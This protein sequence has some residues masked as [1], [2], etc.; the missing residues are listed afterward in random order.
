MRIPGGGLAKSEPTLHCFSWAWLLGRSRAAG[1]A[2]FCCVGYPARYRVKPECRCTLGGGS[3]GWLMKGCRIVPGYAMAG[4]A[5]ALVAMLLEGIPDSRHRNH[6]N[7]RC[8][9]TL[10]AC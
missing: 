1:N 5:D 8:E 10:C 9:P 6:C 4:R 3:L 2:K 7:S